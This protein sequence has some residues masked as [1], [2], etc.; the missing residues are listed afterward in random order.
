MEK[1]MTAYRNP[2]NLT[3]QVSEAI[4]A[5]VQS[6]SSLRARKPNHINQ[7]VDFFNDCFFTLCDNAECLRIVRDPR[8]QYV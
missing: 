3:G 8:G 2:E 1:M 6:T 5:I 4:P 7:N